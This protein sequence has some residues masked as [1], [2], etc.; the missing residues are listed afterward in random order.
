LIELSWFAAD[1]DA[2]QELPLVI[3]RRHQRLQRAGDIV[4][5]FDILDAVD[6][7]ISGTFV[8]SSEDVANINYLEEFSTTDPPFRKIL[9]AFFEVRAFDT[10]YFEIYCVELKLLQVLSDAFSADIECL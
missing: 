8:A 1:I 6:Q 4:R 7:F 3:S 5:M 2:F 10:S 9:G